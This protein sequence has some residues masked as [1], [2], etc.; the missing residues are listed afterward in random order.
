MFPEM[1]HHSGMR[2]LLVEDE[3]RLAKAIAHGLAAEGFEVDVERDGLDGLW[4]AEVGSYAV[5][6]LDILLPGMNGY[7]VCHELRARG[8]TTPVLMLTAKSGEY[9]EVEALDTGA[10]DFLRKPFVFDVLVARLR[11]LLRR[12]HG[13]TGDVLC[14]GDLR[15]DLPARRVARGD[16]EVE[17]TN[18]EYALLVA[19]ARGAGRV[20]GKQELL[21]E[22]WGFDFE[23]DINVVE[24]YVGYLRH[25]LDRPFGK[26]SIETIRGHGYR[27]VPS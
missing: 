23:G 12:S 15:I 24:V 4:R 8:D 17:L 26:E 11:A 9:D 18:R 22:V 2:I 6:I 27:L 21:D 14:A 5:I 19:L 13:Q 7:R 16:V 1:R 10:D 20:R 25:K 3:E